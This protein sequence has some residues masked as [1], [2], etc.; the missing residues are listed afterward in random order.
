MS[1]GFG[2]WGLMGAGAS[3]DCSFLS[4]VYECAWAPAKDPPPFFCQA[5]VLTPFLHSLFQEAGQLL[6]KVR[7]EVGSLRA[8]VLMLPCAVLSGLMGA[9]LLWSLETWR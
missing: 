5:A 3:C 7:G 1:G 6:G 2:S 9:A 4:L 8:G